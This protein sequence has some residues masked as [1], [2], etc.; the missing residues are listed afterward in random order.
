MQ[1]RCLTAYA[2]L[3]EAQTAKIAKYQRQ[4]AAFDRSQLAQVQQKDAKVEAFLKQLKG[5]L[6]RP[7]NCQKTDEIGAI[8]RVDLSLSERTAVGS[9]PARKVVLFITDG[10]HNASKEKLAPTLKSH[11]E[12]LV[13]SNGKGVGIFDSMKHVPFESIDAAIADIIAR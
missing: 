6:A 10:E 13:V 1:F 3:E 8:K 11:A 9:K 4:K 12:T 5:L 2:R 7:A